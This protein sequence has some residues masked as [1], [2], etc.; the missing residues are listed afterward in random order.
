MAG[1]G[2]VQHLDGIRGIAIAAV[3]ALHWGSWYVPVLHGGSIG[4]DMFFVLS[5]FVI[6]TV[7]WRSPTGWA[8]FMRR[9]LARLYPALL[10]LVLGSV[11]LYAAVPWAPDSPLV[12]AERGVL[13]LTQ[14]SSLWAAAQSGSLWLPGLQPFGQTWSRAVEWDFYLMW[15]VVVLRGR[16]VGW[17]ASR[18]AGASLVAAAVAYLVAVPLPTFVFYFGPVERTA[19]LLVGAA[20][21][22]WLVDRE[23]VRRWS[24]TAPLLALAAVAGYVLLGPD[25]QTLAYRYLGIPIAVA[26]ATVLINAGYATTS[27]VAHRLL[28]LPWLAGVGRAS[29]SLYL[30]HVVPFLLL[31][32][33]PLPKP[34]LGV[35][36]V[37]A[38]AALTWA[39][40]RWLERPFL[41]PRSDVLA[42]RPRETAVRPSPAP[43]A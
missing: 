3:L 16:S 33:V 14:T 39:S 7:L 18:R 5:G 36:A 4:V 41:R 15:P 17:S 40:H 21:A 25:G 29:Y 8:P 26:G 27:G 2:R 43:L 23:P 20:L 30:W 24:R 22:L 9:R 28:T 1:K 42:A 11:V 35:L 38:A 13:A 37:G 31:A 6:T 10:G 19:E 12:V 32:D 34:V